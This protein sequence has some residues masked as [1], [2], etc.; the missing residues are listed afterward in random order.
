[1]Y[2]HNPNGSAGGITGVTSTDGRATILMPHPERVFLS[3]Q[4]SWL[5]PAWQSME[6]P[7][8]A[9]FANA[10]RFVA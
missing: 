1:H 6:S 8:F 2:P 5:S 4:F 9:L 10:R 7:W 3:K